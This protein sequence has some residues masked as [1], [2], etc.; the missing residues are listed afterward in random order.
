MDDLGHGRRLRQIAQAPKNKLKD[1]S[2]RLRDRTSSRSTGLQRRTSS[3][4]QPDQLSAPVP[5]P[6]PA[7]SP[8]ATPAL[9]GLPP[10]IEDVRPSCGKLERSASSTNVLGERPP[11]GAGA[12]K[13]LAERRAREGGDAGGMSFTERRS[14]EGPQ[15]PSPLVRKSSAHASIV[16][17]AGWL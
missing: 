11:P 7:A 13:T 9:G 2:S 1:L 8:R 16:D 17:Q 10:V 6:L 5:V 3:G 15:M 12:R 14:A 4:Q